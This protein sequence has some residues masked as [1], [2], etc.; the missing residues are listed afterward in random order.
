M[1]YDCCMS[2][3][4]QMCILFLGSVADVQCL[5]CFFSN[6]DEKNSFPSIYLHPC[7]LR[8]NRPF[9]HFFIIANTLSTSQAVVLFQ[10]LI[11]YVL[12]KKNFKIWRTKISQMSTVLLSIR[13][14]KSFL[15]SKSFWLS[16]VLFYQQELKLLIWTAVSVL[17]FLI[18]ST[19]LNA[20][21]MAI[22]LCDFQSDFE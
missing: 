7:F 16:I 10:N 11:V 1:T 9:F 3:G 17:I 6:M 4:A 21:F 15:L 19:V 18:L 8:F 2:T 22:P 20:S 13:M 14:G 12:P 5:K